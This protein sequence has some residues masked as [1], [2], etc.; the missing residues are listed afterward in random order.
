MS[1][2]PLRTK[3]R[4]APPQMVKMKP[5]PVETSETPNYQKIFDGQHA[6]SPLRQEAHLGPQSKSSPRALLRTGSVSKPSRSDHTAGFCPRVNHHS[7]SALHSAFFK[8]TVL[9]HHK[10]SGGNHRE[11]LIPFP[12]ITSASQRQRPKRWSLQ[13][14]LQKFQISWH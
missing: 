2:A 14:I 13:A 10:H 4:A 5:M 6:G 7:L 3:E 9:S 12:K 8:Q 11:A 1:T